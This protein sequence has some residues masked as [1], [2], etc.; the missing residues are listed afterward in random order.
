MHCEM[1]TSNAAMCIY[2]CMVTD[3]RPHAHNIIVVSGKQN[4]VIIGRKTWESIP[5]K[6]R[7]LKDRYNIVLSSKKRSVSLNV[8]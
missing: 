5:A 4:A 7:P 6:I 1:Y 8:W 3:Q 2:K